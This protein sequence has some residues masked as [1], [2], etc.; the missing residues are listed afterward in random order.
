MPYTT[1]LIDF[2]HKPQWLLDVNPAGSVPVMKVCPVAGL[3]IFYEFQFAL[4]FQ[5]ALHRTTPELLLGSCPMQRSLHCTVACFLLATAHHL[6]SD[7]APPQQYQHCSTLAHRILKQGSGLL[8][9]ARLQTTW[10]LPT[11]THRWEPSTPH[12]RCA[13]S[14]EPASLCCRGVAD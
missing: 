9:A 7:Y 3:V 5:F 1:T 13:C 6:S 10:R 14:G 12:L 11:L 4:Q 2:D 8:T